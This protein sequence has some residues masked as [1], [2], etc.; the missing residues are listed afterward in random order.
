MRTQLRASLVAQRKA[1]RM[2]QT[3]VATRMSTT[4]SFVSE[5][6]NGGTD[7]HLS[8]LQR[9]GRAVAA[10]LTVKI[11]LPAHCDWEPRERWAQVTEQTRYGNRTTTLRHA[12]PALADRR[13]TAET[14][15]RAIERV[16][17]GSVRMTVSV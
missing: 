3:Q 2:T 9:Y 1:M 7:P 8:T 11:E 13:V 15:S 16:D 14:W 10:R 12:T 4:Q 6:E 5:F 17:T